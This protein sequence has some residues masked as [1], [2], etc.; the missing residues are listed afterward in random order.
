M[1]QPEGLPEGRKVWRQPEPD[2]SAW[3]QRGCGQERPTSHKIRILCDPY[4]GVALAGPESVRSAAEDGLGIPARSRAARR[5]PWRGADS[6]LPTTFAFTDQR[7]PTKSR[8]ALLR[9]RRS[10]HHGAPRRRDPRSA[11]AR[12]VTGERRSWRS[13]CIFSAATVSTPERRG[14]INRGRVSDSFPVGGGVLCAGCARCVVDVPSTFA[15]S[16]PPPEGN[17]ADDDRLH[18][19]QRLRGEERRAWH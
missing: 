10:A 7:S 6:A 15:E 18:Y 8:G 9:L 4:S 12:G 5:C 3:R 13:C 19:R 17:S 2:F 14:S 1:F 16:M 11:S